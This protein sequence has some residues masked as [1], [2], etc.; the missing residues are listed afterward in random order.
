MRINKIR[1]GGYMIVLNEL[2]NQVKKIKGFQTR[3][4]RHARNRN[5]IIGAGIG[6]ALGL[7]AGILF[8]PKSGREIRQGISDRT[9]EAA[10]NLKENVAATRARMFDAASEKDGHEHD[11][12]K[13]GGD[14]KNESTK[15]TG[16]D[17]GKETTK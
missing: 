7:A 10:K 8:A 5:M 14:P 3:T 17:K 12:G 15:K 2:A 13:K 16:D 9:C 1:T 4:M 11:T 6:S